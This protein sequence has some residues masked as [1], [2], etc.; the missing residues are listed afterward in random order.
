ML[1]EPC[2]LLVGF[3]GKLHLIEVKVSEKEARRSD[4][5]T[6]ARQ[7]E[8]RENAERVGCTI[9]VVWTERMALEAIGVVKATT[10]PPE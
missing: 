6:A 9:H 5:N 2:D 8:H 1:N 3:R 7:R 10:P 4:T